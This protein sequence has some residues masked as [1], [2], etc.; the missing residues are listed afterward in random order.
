MP[1]DHDQAAAGTEYPPG[2]AQAGVDVGPVMGSG[3]RPQHRRRVV[4]EWERFGRTLDQ[5]R[6][7]VPAQQACHAQHGRRRI[8]AGDRC[9]HRCRVADRGSGSASHVDNSIT[10]LEGAETRNQPGVALT[11]EG[12]SEGDEP[13]PRAGETLV[14]GVVIR[15][16]A[17]VDHAQTLTVEP[18]FKSSGSVPDE[19]LTIGDVADRAGVATSAIRYYERLGLLKADARQSGQRRYRIETL[20]RLVFIGMLQDAGLVLDDIAGILNAKDMAEWKAIGRERLAALDDEIARLQHAREVL[21][22]ALNC[23]YDHPATDCK[24]MGAEIDRRLA[25]RVGELAQ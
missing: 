12:E 13:S 20:R 3:Y 1:F 18:N 9:A 24:I 2:L 11:P 15:Y 4:V 7:P 10:R 17:L 23:R 22:A 8:D 14:V 6:V 19:L 16:C 21:A 25:S 5:A